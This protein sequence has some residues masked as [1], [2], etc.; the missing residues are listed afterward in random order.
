MTFLGIMADQV[1]GGAKSKGAASLAVEDRRPK[2]PIEQLQLLPDTRGKKSKAK[3]EGRPAVAPPKEAKRPPLDSKTG[4]SIGHKSIKSKN[5]VLRKATI[6]PRTDLMYHGMLES[7]QRYDPRLNHRTAGVQ[8]P[9]APDLAHDHFLELDRNQDG[10]VDPV[11]RA[12]GRLDIDRD[13]Q[14]RQP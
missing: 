1:F 2:A 11:E 12:F 3:A 5:K 6:Q 13:L 10:N 14:H 9:Q 8:D 7:S 4:N